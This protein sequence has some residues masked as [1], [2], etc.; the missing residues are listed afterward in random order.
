[1]IALLLLI[2]TN[3]SNLINHLSRTDN[4]H[5]TTKSQVG[6]GNVETIMDANSCLNSY[7]KRLL[8]LK[9]NTITGTTKCNLKSVGVGG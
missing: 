9:Q 7:S 8:N 1:M 4:P 6:L 2:A 3:G 5:N